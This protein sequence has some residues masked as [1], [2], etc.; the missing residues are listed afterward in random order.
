MAKELG[1]EQVFMY[2]GD[3]VAKLLPSGLTPFTHQIGGLNPTKPLKDKC[4]LP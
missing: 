4:K 3:L 2:N 1:N